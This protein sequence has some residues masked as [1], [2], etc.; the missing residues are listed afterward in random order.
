MTTYRNGF[1][2]QYV[3][4]NVLYMDEFEVREWTNRYKEYAMRQLSHKELREI[5]EEEVNLN[6]IDTQGSVYVEDEEESEFE[7]NQFLEDE[8]QEITAYFKG[9]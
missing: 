3:L 2:A 5:K 1:P 9:E 7:A 4:D 6:L 8:P